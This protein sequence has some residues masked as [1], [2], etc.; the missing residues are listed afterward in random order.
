MALDIRTLAV[1]LAATVA[2]AGLV[3]WLLYRLHPS[4]PGPREWAVGMGLLASGFLL[5]F[6]R[7]AIPDFVSIV[8]ANGAIGFG[9]LSVYLGM[10]RFVGKPPNIGWP[11]SIVICG[12][13][14]FFFLY[15]S[16]SYLAERIVIGA[17]LAAFL[18]LL[19]ASGARHGF[20]RHPAA[21]D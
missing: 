11:L 14:P 2:T 3:T 1:L 13:V 12:W 6:A 17:I 16:A 19:I 8:I 4:L 18:S 21:V 15:G 5:I 7:G 10:R 9:Y 20:L